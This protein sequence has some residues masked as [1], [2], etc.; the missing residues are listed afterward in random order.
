MRIVILFGS[1]IFGLC[2]TNVIWLWFLLYS[3]ED[4]NTVVVTASLG[5]LSWG[6]IVDSDSSNSNNDATNGQEIQ[7]TEGMILLWT[8]GGG[9][10]ALFDNTIWYVTACVCCLPGRSLG[11]LGKYRWCGS[12]IVVFAVVVFTVLRATLDSNEQDVDLSDLGTAGINDDNIKLGQT[13][14][15]S[16]YQ[17]TIGYA[18]ELVLA[19]LVYY[20]LVGTILFTGVLVCGKIPVLGGRPYE[21]L[22]QK[23]HA[24]ASNYRLNQV[25]GFGKEIE[26]LPDLLPE[27]LH[28]GADSTRPTST[29]V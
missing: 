21:V 3:E 23:R 16:A 20:P 26:S 4:A 2:V 14:E 8:V 5:G 12:Y 7:I 29:I 17:F 25:E 13:D 1:I 24:Q 19:L 11:C 9:L 28:A 22:V 27:L 15:A 18:V 10:H 6:P